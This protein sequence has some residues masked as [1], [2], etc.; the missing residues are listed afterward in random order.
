MSAD[1]HAIVIV[2]PTGAPLVVPPHAMVNVA[3][4]KDD[5]HFISG[6]EVAFP[7]VIASQRS[8]VVR[9]RSDRPVGEGAGG[10]GVA[11]E[12]GLVGHL[13]VLHLVEDD[14]VE[15]AGI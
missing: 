6:I 14:L 3:V 7:E 1:D 4:G 13:D 15:L 5:D 12:V 10:L 9:G 11:V 8:V 2:F